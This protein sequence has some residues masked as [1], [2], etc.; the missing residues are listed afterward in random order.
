MKI[1]ERIEHISLLDGKENL[2]LLHISDIHL[3]YSTKILDHLTAII[4]KNHPALIVMTG[5]YY[6]VPKGAYNFRKFLIE[7]AQKQPVVFIRGNHDTIYGSGISDL[8]LDI[9]NCFCVEN[10]VFKYQ[11]YRG[12]SYNFTSWK[13]KNMLPNK[14]GESNIVL[15]HNPQKIKDQEL[16]NIDIVLAGHLHGGQFIFF[17]TKND[18]YFPGNV[19]YKFCTDRKRIG[20]TTLIISKGLGDT[21]PFRWNCPKEVV[22]LIIK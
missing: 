19:L 9:P 22:E 1:S 8:L 21:F 11:S 14:N 17:K 2:N 15:I 4:A 10:S 20:S 5:D 6:D 3:W 12:Y 13:N 18:T 7:V 16:T